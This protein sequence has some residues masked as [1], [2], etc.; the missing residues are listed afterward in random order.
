MSQFSEF[1]G[2]KKVK[3][4]TVTDP[5]EIAS[6]DEFE[7]D[8]YLKDLMRKSGF[9]RTIRTGGNKP[10]LAASSYLGAI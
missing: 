5:E 8:A 4:P 10:K 6:M 3:V 1:L 7:S 2:L 9:E